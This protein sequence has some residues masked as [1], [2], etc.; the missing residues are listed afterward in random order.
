MLPPLLSAV[1]FDF[2]AAQTMATQLQLTNGYIADG[3]CF[4]RAEGAAL[5]HP[6]LVG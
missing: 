4:C 1:H 2:D 6:G 3:V 5:Y